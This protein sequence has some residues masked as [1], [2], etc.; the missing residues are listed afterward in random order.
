[1]R[2]SSAAG[3]LARSGADGVG[4]CAGVLG[5]CAGEGGRSISELWQ[6]KA[7]WMS[8]SSSTSSLLC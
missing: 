5:V 7:E 2:G 3:S 4:E 8:N 6:E 1:M